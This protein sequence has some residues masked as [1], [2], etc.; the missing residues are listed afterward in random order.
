MRLRACVRVH[1]CV[2]ID[3]CRCITCTDGCT[4]AHTVA[5]HNQRTHSH[6]HASA[7]MHS[8]AHARTPRGHHA[9]AATGTALGRRR[10][11]P[12]R[13][14]ASST[15]TRGCQASRSSGYARQACRLHASQ[16]QQ[17]LGRMTQR[18]SCDEL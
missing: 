12:T 16:R 7:R 18:L 17:R 8:C 1:T 14:D 15:Q 9:A 11:G 5:A 6:A 4:V 13:T 10:V 3:V 2:R